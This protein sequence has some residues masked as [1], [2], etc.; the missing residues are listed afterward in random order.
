[1]KNPI[2]KNKFAGA[3]LLATALFGFAVFIY[4]LVYYVYEYDPQYYPVDYGRFNFLFFF[5]VQSN[6]FAY[7]YFFF[8]G[9][10]MLGVKKAET[11][12]FHS[13]FGTLATLYVVVAGA[14]YCGGLPFG[15]AP[16]FT[17][18]TPYHR[19]TVVIQIF[20]HMFMPAAALLLY[21]FPF[22]N[23]RLGKRTVLLSGIYP[24]VYSVFS[25]IRG[26]FT[27]PAYYP[28][29]FYDPDFVWRTLM[30]DRPMNLF[31][32]YAIIGLCIAAV[33][34]GLFMALC[35]ALVWVHNKRVSKTDQ[36]E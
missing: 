14:V 29:P 11:V 15:F 1:M 5:T 24:V 2:T 16:P 30:K 26:R 12:G 22:R 35:A 17:W 8:A 31:A 19:M 9:L 20:Y 28:Y 34:C 23:E 25:L 10:A 36:A 6:F 3:I 33:G 21:C 7:V 18:D 27:V 32:A 13:G 4:R